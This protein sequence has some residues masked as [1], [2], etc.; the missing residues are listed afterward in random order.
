MNFGNIA[1][2]FYKAIGKQDHIKA[3]NISCKKYQVYIILTYKSFQELLQFIRTYVSAMQPEQLLCKKLRRSRRKMPSSS[4]SR[5]KFR[6]AL[7]FWTTRDCKK[8][9]VELESR[10]FESFCL[11]WKEP[12]ELGTSLLELKSFFRSWKVSLK[13][14]SFAAFGKFLLKLES[15]NALGKL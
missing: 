8:T 5:L 7:Q 15:L 6:Q 2:I 3:T 14:E 11:I 4:V 10:N 9:V 12:N 13:M 1:H